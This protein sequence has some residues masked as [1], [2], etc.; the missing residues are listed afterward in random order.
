MK[1]NQF[2]FKKFTIRQDKCTM[3][4][5]TDAVLLGAWVKP[6]AALN[7]LDIGTGTGVV[8]LML[9]QKTNANI[10]AIDI[11]KD[12]IQ[13]ATQNIIECPFEAHIQALHTSFQEFAKS[14]IRK[15]D[16]I[17]SNP[18]FYPYS[19]KILNQPRSLA[20]HAET[21][22]FEELIDGAIQVLNK[23][24]RF[25]LILPKQEAEVF[26]KIARQK[27]LHLV[28][29]LRVRTKPDKETEKRHLMEFRFE[30]L[31]FNESTLVIEKDHHFDYTQEYKNLTQDYYLNF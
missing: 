22:P 20:R 6:E 18:P 4:V 31:E 3:K 23:D 7:I 25:C 11:D 16:L 29:L 5:N 28:K 17:V 26:T 13:Q 8:A 12:S 21:L 1:G 30:E 9:A 15:F 24:G 14:S 10:L 2:V 19:V 27:N